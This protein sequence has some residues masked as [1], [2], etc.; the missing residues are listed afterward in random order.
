MIKVHLKNPGHTEQKLRFGK[1]HTNEG[2]NLN[3][4]AELILV[5]SSNPIT[6]PA[7]EGRVSDSSEHVAGYHDKGG[8]NCNDRP[9]PFILHDWGDELEEE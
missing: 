8:E 2:H 9:R 3:F 6:L 7:V 1:G 4:L 5:P